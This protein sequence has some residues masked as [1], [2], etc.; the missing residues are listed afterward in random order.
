MFRGIFQFFINSPGVAW[1]IVFFLAII[2]AI[3]L[4]EGSGMD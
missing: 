2:T 4:I 3:I 1:S